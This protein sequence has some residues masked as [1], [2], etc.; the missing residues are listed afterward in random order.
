[1]ELAMKIT[2][3]TKKEFLIDK[4]AKEACTVVFSSFC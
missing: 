4:I 2:T 1:M 3:T